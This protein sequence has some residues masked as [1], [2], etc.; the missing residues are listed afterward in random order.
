MGMCGA[1][2]DRYRLTGYAD[3]GLFAG[4]ALGICTIIATSSHLAHRKPVFRTVYR[5]L[6]TRSDYSSPCKDHRGH[7]DDSQWSM[8]GAWH[9]RTF[10][11]CLRRYFN[12]YRRRQ[13]RC[14]TPKP[15]IDLRR[16]FRHLS[17]RKNTVL[18]ARLERVAQRF[19][20]VAGM[21]RSNL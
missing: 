20:F 8:V 15:T 19:G 21:Q 14:N 10:D 11:R 5:R 3:D 1:R 12:S 2:G 6:G 16:L 18:P 4:S 17:G 9:Q 7:H 13:L